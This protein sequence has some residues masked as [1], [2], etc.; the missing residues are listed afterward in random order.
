MV[1]LPW[2]RVVSVRSSMQRSVKVIFLNWP[3]GR[4]LPRRA[5]SL[6]PRKKGNDW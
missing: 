5:P 2:L 3:M 6:S 1:V 4:E